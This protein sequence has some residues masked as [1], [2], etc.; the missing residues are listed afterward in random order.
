MGDASF[1]CIG[2]SYVSKLFKSEKRGRAIGVIQA[3]EMIGSFLGQTVGGYV[4]ASY[5]PRM[6]FLATTIIAI[7]ALLSVT[8]I[9]SSVE[10]LNHVGKIS[11]I[12]TRKEML[13][14]LNRTV[15]VVCGI[16][17]ICM[18]INNGIINTILPIF[19]T[20]NIGLSLAQY[21][22]LVSSSTVG[23]MT[24]N[25]VGGVLSDRI[26]RKKVL[27]LGFI[28]GGGALFSLTLFSNFYI[29]L[30][31]MFFN[32]I[33]WGVV[34]GVA[35]AYIADAV[36]SEVRGIGIGT[37]RTFMDM[38][39]LIEPIIMSKLAETVGGTQGIKYTFYSGAIML[40]GLIVLTST[41]REVSSSNE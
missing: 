12:P 5:G 27:T 25:L 22:F 40:A 24:G 33:F 14:V 15:I 13:K 39:G 28:I 8:Q 7:V 16:N 38:G 34:Y 11:F 30:I 36:P 41:I 35:P 10:P 31:L 23:S 37:F 2:M 18:I 4:A 19:A 6:N 20:E 17:L 9:R 26:G 3:V 29:L 32:G 1:F 21:A